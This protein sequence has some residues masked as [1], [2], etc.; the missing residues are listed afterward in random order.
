MSASDFDEEEL[1]LLDLLHAP[2]DSYLHHLA[3][4]MARVESL[5]HVLAWAKYDERRT[6]G[7]GDAISQ[8]ELRLVSLISPLHLAYISPVSRRPSCASSRCPASS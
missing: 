5:S 4:V 8:A 7:R 1:V 2:A 6:L 3:S